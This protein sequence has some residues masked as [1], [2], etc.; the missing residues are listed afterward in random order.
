MKNNTLTKGIKNTEIGKLAVHYCVIRKIE[1]RHRQNGSPY[2]VLELGDRSGRLKAKIWDRVVEYT[3]RVRV[4]EIVKIRAIVQVFN[5]RK[6]LKIQKLKA[7]D[8]SDGIRLI[9][10]LP[11]SSKNID[12]LTKQLNDHQGTIHNT[13]LRSFLEA[14]F[15]DV[16]FAAAFFRSP[17][18][19]LWHHN[20]LFGMLEK[21][22]A[23]LDIADAL[24]AHYPGLN[25]DLLKTGIICHDIG[26]VREYQLHGFID[27]SDAGRLVG[28]TA[29]GY[30]MM[31]EVI[32][33]LE[34]FPEHLKMQLVHL[35]LSHEGE[36]QLGA[37]VRPMTLEATVLHHILNL[38]ANTNALCRIIETD[39]LP[40][41]NWTKYNPLLERFIYLGDN[42]NPDSQH[43]F[44][45]SR[46]CGDV[47]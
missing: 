12:A 19:K 35:V 26:K 43:N 33:C 7:V 1:Q 46:N 42:S 15:K 16:E 27:F 6:E 21:V 31:V 37:P 44:R 47:D 23:M 2:L 22:V 18:G 5:G 41:S 10:L 32:T 14:L 17:S 29:M 4:G 39:G 40:G 20:Y 30:E 34:N 9:D 25:I 38:V 24:K 45:S 36:H 13:N 28:H 3:K 8:E 11:M